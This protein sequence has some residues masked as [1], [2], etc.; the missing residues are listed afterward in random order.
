MLYIRTGLMGHGKTLNTIKEVDAKAKAEG[1]VVY[2]ANLTG[3]KPDK[4]RAEWYEFDDPHTWY[5]LPNDAIIVVDEA[6]QFFGTRDPRKDVPEYC[7][8]WEIMRKQGHEMHLITQDPRFLDVHARRLCNKHIHYSRIFGSSKL[9]RYEAERCYETVDK[10]PTYKLADKTTISLDKKFF[11]VYQSAQAG[12]HFKFKP[13]KKAIVFAVVAVFAVFALY[14]A[15]DTIFN[16][17]DST[18]DLES[19]VTGTVVSQVEAAIAASPVGGFLPNDQSSSR[20]MTADEYLAARQPR[21]HNLPSSAP[22]Y[23]QLTE[24]KTHPRLYCTYSQDPAFIER[25]SHDV[26]VYGGVKTSCVC[27]TQQV[28]KADVGFL[29]CM[30]AAKHGYFDN[31]IP[32]SQPQISQGMVGQQTSFQP[33]QQQFHTGYGDGGQPIT[34]EST[35]V[36]VV[37]YQKGQFLW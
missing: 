3:L 20:P 16:K 4:L 5:D 10:F 22:I 8:R 35:R 33:P 15:Y 13:S 29:F 1:R 32:D 24:P 27:Y 2:Y 7:S 26:G 23:D 11:G 18:D 36:T 30:N 9:V 28:T 34:Q 25:T 6:Q 31:T 19:G 17:D 12:H 37:P 14:R 21:I